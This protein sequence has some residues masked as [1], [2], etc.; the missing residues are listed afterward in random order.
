[1]IAELKRQRWLARQIVEAGLERERLKRR[2]FQLGLEQGMSRN[3][4]QEARAG[5]RIIE[6]MMRDTRRYTDI[7]VPQR[8]GRR[9]RRT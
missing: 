7:L 8:R 1:M 6:E 5:D 9:G 3:R 4:L 2:V